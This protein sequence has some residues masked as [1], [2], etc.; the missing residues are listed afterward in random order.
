MRY[1]AYLERGETGQARAF[2]V[3]EYRDP[4]A[5]TAMGQIKNSLR[6]KL[7]ATVATYPQFDKIK[8]TLRVDG[9]GTFATYTELPPP[10]DLQLPAVPL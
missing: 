10:P 7:A 8:D 3:L 9:F 2:N 1:T 6:E 4:V 5:F